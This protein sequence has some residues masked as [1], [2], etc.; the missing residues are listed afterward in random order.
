MLSTGAGVLAGLIPRIKSASGNCLRKAGFRHH[1]SYDSE[2]CH[3]T[4]WVGE[5]KTV[6]EIVSEANIP[7]RSL[8]SKT[9]RTCLLALRLVTGDQIR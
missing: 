9:T 3:F 5:H 6:R 1:S 7:C 8:D 2:I 4:G